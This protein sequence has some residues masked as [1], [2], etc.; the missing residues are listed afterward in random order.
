MSYTYSPRERT[1][2]SRCDGPLVHWLASFSI[3][4]HV[5]EKHTLAPAMDRAITSIKRRTICTRECHRSACIAATKAVVFISQREYEVWAFEFV[6]DR[7]WHRP[8][9]IASKG[10]GCD[11]R[12]RSDWTTSSGDAG[13]CSVSV[14]MSPW[15]CRVEILA[16]PRRINEGFSIIWNRVCVESYLASRDKPLAKII[17]INAY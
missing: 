5:I 17:Y 14:F 3:P 7:S 13:T 12:T 2:T 4:S 11:G 10:S 6:P 15:S 8:N 16:L 1:T 9:G